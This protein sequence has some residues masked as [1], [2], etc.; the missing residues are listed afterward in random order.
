MEAPL[1]VPGVCS[2]ADYLVHAAGD[3]KNCPRSAGVTL[4]QRVNSSLRWLCLFIYF[5]DAFLDWFIEKPIVKH[6][7]ELS[8]G[9]LWL[10]AASD[11][12][13]AAI[14]GGLCCTEL[15][16]AMAQTL[17]LWELPDPHVQ[18]STPQ[19]ASLRGKKYIIFSAKSP[20][21]TTAMRLCHTGVLQGMSQPLRSQALHASS[22]GLL[23]A[24]AIFLRA[25]R[26]AG[27]SQK[28]SVLLLLA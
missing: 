6:C 9:R 3:Q 14:S 16:S 23:P 21:G 11:L 24:K 15:H 4:Q 25:I 2:F 7:S 22:P 10:L 18:P 26:P 20:F 8:F 12:N 17:H 1:C 5:L 19:T 28:M 27:N 13:A